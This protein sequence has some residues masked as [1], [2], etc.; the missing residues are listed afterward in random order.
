MSNIMTVEPIFGVLR[1]VQGYCE[2]D[3]FVVVAIAATTM[4]VAVAIL[5]AAMGPIQR[6]FA[7]LPIMARTVGEAL[8]FVT[9]MS[10]GLGIVFLGFALVGW[11]MGPRP[12]P[13][14]MAEPPAL[15]TIVASAS[16]L[17]ATC[18]PGFLLGLLMTMAGRR[19]AVGHA[20]AAG[21]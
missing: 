15:A 6:L 7:E 13:F 1:A 19:A 18:I 4:V 10:M 11:A 16:V 9:A 20:K 14:G 8:V 12:T 2:S 17:Y 21:P 3:P 5:A